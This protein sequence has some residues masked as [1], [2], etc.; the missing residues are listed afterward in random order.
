M[1]RNKPEET[2]PRDAQDHEFDEDEKIDEGIDESFPAS[3]PPSFTP[4]TPGEP[5]PD[6]A[7]SPR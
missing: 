5:D 2:V 1:P 7:H 3:D 4:T 6:P